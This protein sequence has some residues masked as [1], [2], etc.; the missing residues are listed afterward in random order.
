MLILVTVRD[1]CRLKG[2]A[3]SALISVD[4]AHWLWDGA[5]LEP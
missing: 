4:F 2:A 5:G 1:G 3:D